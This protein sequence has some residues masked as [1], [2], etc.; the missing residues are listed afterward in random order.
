MILARIITTI[1]CVHHDETA[2]PFLLGR[3]Y[4]NKKNGTVD[5]FAA[6]VAHLPEKSPNSHSREQ[7]RVHIDTRSIYILLWIYIPRSISTLGPAICTKLAIDVVDDVL[8]LPHLRSQ[9]LDGRPEPRAR[10][11][12]QRYRDGEKK[13][14][15]GRR[16]RALREGKHTGRRPHEGQSLEKRSNRPQT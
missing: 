12:P 11:R 16:L 14:C 7:K 15:L 1:A 13:G 6:N 5:K 2:A 9:V 3:K 4:Q 10:A 8:L